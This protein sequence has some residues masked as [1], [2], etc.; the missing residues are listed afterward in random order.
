LY[1][2]EWR[3]SEVIVCEFGDAQCVLPTRQVAA[4]LALETT[5]AERGNIDERA[6]AS[7][8]CV[9]FGRELSRRIGTGTAD[10]RDDRESTERAHG[11]T[12]PTLARRVVVLEVIAIPVC[13]ALCAI[14]VVAPRSVNERSY[15]D[16]VNAP[17]NPEASSHGN[18][19]L[20]CSPLR[21]SAIAT[22][23]VAFACGHVA[24]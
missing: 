20:A 11:T 8:D 19:T 5:D 21:W 3:K 9:R 24:G 2:R 1:L 14:V 6:V 12:N 16:G 18:D 17:L 7:G 22:T 23:T 13:D 10:Q 4:Q 15:V